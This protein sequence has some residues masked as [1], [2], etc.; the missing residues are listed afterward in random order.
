MNKSVGCFDAR[1]KKSYSVIVYIRAVLSLIRVESLNSARIKSLEF[2]DMRLILSVLLRDCCGNSKVILY[3]P[4]IF[5]SYTCIGSVGQMHFDSSIREYTYRASRTIL[6]QSPLA[7]K[8]LGMMNMYS[9]GCC[10]FFTGEIISYC[11]RIFKSLTTFSCKCSGTIIARYS[12]KNASGSIGRC[13]GECFFPTS[14][15]DVA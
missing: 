1:I 8:I 10:F 9:L 6:N 5:V 12:L 14:N 11:S 4:F 3:C 15:L 2:A 7:R 13:G